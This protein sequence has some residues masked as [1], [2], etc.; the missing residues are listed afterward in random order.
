MRFI[1]ISALLGLAACV[2]DSHEAPQQEA[3]Q[4]DWIAINLPLGATPDRE[5]NTSWECG[6]DQQLSCA[7]DAGNA[8]CSCVYQQSARIQLIDVPAQQTAAQSSARH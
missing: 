8:T 7:T 5:I 1:L 4:D 3:R 6:D 2:S